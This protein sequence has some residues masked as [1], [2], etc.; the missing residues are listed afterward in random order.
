MKTVKQLNVSCFKTFFIFISLCFIDADINP[1]PVTEPLMTG[2]VIASC[3]FT[4]YK[5][6][7]ILLS[8]MIQSL[9]LARCL[10]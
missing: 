8:V 1:Q 10:K 7:M 2:K 3:I 6:F 5:I 4:Y 9:H